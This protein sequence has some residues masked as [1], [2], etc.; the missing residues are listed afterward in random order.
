ML[1]SLAWYNGL[2]AGGTPG[3]LWGTPRV[4]GPMYPQV[5]LNT[6]DNKR[7]PFFGDFFRGGGV[8]MYLQMNKRTSK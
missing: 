5:T 3:Y 6:P 4:P 1:D 7:K 8:H 2:G